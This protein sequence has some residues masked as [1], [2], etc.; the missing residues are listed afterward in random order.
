[1]MIAGLL[2][3]SDKNI[4][5]T[6]YMRQRNAMRDANILNDANQSRP[7]TVKLAIFPA[8]RAATGML[9]SEKRVRLPIAVLN[10]PQTSP[11][12]TDPRWDLC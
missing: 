6:A 3:P 8:G 9:P 7:P 11:T 2:E 10:V 5:S 12:W 1:M 4:D